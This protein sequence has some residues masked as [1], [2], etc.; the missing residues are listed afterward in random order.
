MKITNKHPPFLASRKMNIVYFHISYMNRIST[1]L[2]ECWNE[3]PNSRPDIEKVYEILIQLRLTIDE[4][5]YLST[6]LQPQNNQPSQE[7]T[8]SDATKLN[9]NEDKERKKG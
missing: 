4:S 8:S 3:V 5:P 7:S 2:S 9:I 6:Y 1:T